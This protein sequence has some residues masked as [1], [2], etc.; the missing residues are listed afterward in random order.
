MNTRPEGRLFVA[1]GVCGVL[2]IL[3]YAV[4]IAVRL[5]NA[6]SFAL[7][8]LWPI[9]SVA[10]V[11]ALYRLVA[12]E[13]QGPLNRLACIMAIVGFAIVAC[14]LSVQLAVK[15]GVE[16]YLIGA[17]AGEEHNWRIML[18]ALRLV[19]MGLDVAWDMFI[20][21]ALILVAVPMYS[22]SRLGRWWSIP[23]AVLG[24]LLILFN[25]YTFPWP[26]N[27]QGLIDVGPIIG[28]YII[29]LS[30]RLTIIGFRVNRQP[31]SPT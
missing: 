12:T 8:M 19:D 17:A 1:G 28:L 5:P 15:I 16:E 25:A 18:R 21:T 9:L 24:L 22:H 11:F 23:S 10:Y 4:I 26:P 31:V 7:A 3:C 20:G 30:I 27:T 29:A 6:V 13:R 14:M 2:S